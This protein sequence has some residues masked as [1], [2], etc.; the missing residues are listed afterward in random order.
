MVVS[1]RV[2][3]INLPKRGR[4]R[5]MQKMFQKAAPK[6]SN[7]TSVHPST[8]RDAAWAHIFLVQFRDLS[9]PGRP[10]GMQRVTPNLNFL[11]ANTKL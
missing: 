8:K 2:L 3:Y 5:T 9:C 11:N 6:Y 7:Y 1:G 4:M 10:M